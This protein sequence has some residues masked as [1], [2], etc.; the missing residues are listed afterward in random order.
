MEANSD[1]VASDS[2]ASTPGKISETTLSRE[3]ATVSMECIMREMIQYVEN[4]ITTAMISKKWSAGV[5]EHLINL[6]ISI[7]RIYEETGNLTWRLDES[8]RSLATSREEN[9]ILQKKIVEL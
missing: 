3:A 7:R 2:G 1:G 8:R 9:A 5:N 6:A 4:M